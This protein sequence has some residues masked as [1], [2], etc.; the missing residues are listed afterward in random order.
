M[1]EFLFLLSWLM[2][3]VQSFSP[4]KINAQAMRQANSLFSF[5]GD[6]N[7]EIFVRKQ[8]TCLQRI[9]AN[10]SKVTSILNLIQIPIT[11]E[12]RTQ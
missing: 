10:V 8:N 12:I 4:S 2:K 3:S 6:R 9:N 5:F 7:K 1:V 11:G